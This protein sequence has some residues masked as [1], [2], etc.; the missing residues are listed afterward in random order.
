[1]EKLNPTLTSI[2]FSGA[3]CWDA[4]QSPTSEVN[5]KNALDIRDSPNYTSM[6]PFGKETQKQIRAGLGP[7]RTISY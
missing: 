3:L 6:R 7:K 2:S 4:N 5:A 1:M